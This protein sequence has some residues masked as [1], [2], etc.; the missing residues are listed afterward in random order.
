MNQPS[1][2]IH[3]NDVTLTIGSQNL[4]QNISFA[5]QPAEIITLLGPNGAGKTSLARLLVGLDQPTTGEIYRKP[6]L[7]LGY[8]P[9]QMNLK[10]SLPLTVER[11]LKSGRSQDSSEHDTA[12]ELAQASHLRQKPVEVLSGGERQRILLARAL[13]G[14]PDLLIL[15]E[16][17]QGIDLQG[18]EEL[19]ALLYDIQ[20]IHKVGIFLISHDLHIV[21][22]ES[23]HIMCLNKHLCCSGSSEEIQQNPAFLKM[24]GLD[25]A[26]HLAIYRHRHDHKHGFNHERN[27]P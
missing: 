26:A 22:S 10:K 24:F 13:L 17:M 25:S 16:P 1:E 8:V 23:N 19:Y 21:M 7:T 14:K 11:F 2:L 27:S 9:Q 6:E 15:D 20:S 3:F 12:L 4:V 18:Q 5:I